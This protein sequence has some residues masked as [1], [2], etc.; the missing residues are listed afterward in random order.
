[1]REGFHAGEAGALL[2]SEVPSAGV[3]FRGIADF[4][5]ADLLAAWR[6]QIVEQ[7]NAA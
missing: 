4:N 1:V 2:R 7:V 6:R 3:S 5:Y